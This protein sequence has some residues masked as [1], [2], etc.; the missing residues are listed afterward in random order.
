MASKKTPKKTSKQTPKK[1]GTRKR[2]GVTLEPTSLGAQELALST[3]PLAL[4]GSLQGIAARVTADGGAVLAAYREPLGGRDLLLVSLPTQLVGPTPFQRDVSDAHVRKLTLAMDKTR[5]FLDPLIVV[6]AE[7]LSG[8]T[9]GEAEARA[10]QAGVPA[11]RYLTPNGNHRLTALKELGANAVIGLLVPE[12]E[13][14][15]QILALNIEK[16]HNLRERALEVVRMYR[17]LA[18]WCDQQEADLSLEFEEP[19]LATLGFAYEK[20]ARLSGGAYNPVLRKVDGWLEQKLPAAVVE[21]ERR[22][23]VLLALDDAVAGAVARFK[24]AGLTSPYL[25]NFVVARVNPL[26]FIKGDPPS[27]DELLQT[28][29]KRAE[30]LDPAKIR[31]EDLAKSGGGPGDD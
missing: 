7:T 19:G 14:A 10:D 17:D 3:A 29:T 28:M 11:Y 18:G 8:R 12:P 27:F 2:R 31:A 20:R 21:R 6:R 1:V 30:K 4:P 25:K 9:D 24:A 22:A 26:R 15:Y 23:H 5:R 13:V 16:A